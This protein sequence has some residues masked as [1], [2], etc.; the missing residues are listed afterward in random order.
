MQPVMDIGV[1]FTLKTYIR[2]ESV[3]A[4]FPNGDYESL[5]Y[6]LMSDR[7]SRTA[8]LAATGL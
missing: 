7:L 5:I 4:H 2:E 6:D 8:G 1:A 3:L